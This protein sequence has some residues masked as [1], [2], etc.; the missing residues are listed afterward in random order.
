LRYLLFVLLSTAM[1]SMV[2]SGTITGKVTSKESGEAL[3]G[4]NVYL[5]GIPLGAATD[6]GGGIH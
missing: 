4:A 1:V 2:L 3:W 5:Q 6:E